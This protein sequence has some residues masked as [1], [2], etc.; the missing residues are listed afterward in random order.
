MAIDFTPQEKILM[1]QHLRDM[2]PQDIHLLREDFFLE[3][4]HRGRQGALER[5]LDNRFT[6]NLQRNAWALSGALEDPMMGI[7]RTGEFFDQHGVLGGIGQIAYSTAT[8]PFQAAG[9]LISGEGL[10]RRPIETVA[11]LIAFV[12]QTRLAT[13]GAG[14][15]LRAAAARGI[16]GGFARR[17]MMDMGGEAMQRAAMSNIARRASGVAETLDVAAGLQEWP[18]E[19]GA[20]VGMHVGTNLLVQAPQL[21]HELSQP[22][23]IQPSP[24]RT[25]QM[26]QEL[27]AEQS[28]PLPA[29]DPVMIDQQTAPP[30]GSVEAVRQWQ[31]QN[32][33]TPTSPFE[34]VQR[35]I[36]GIKQRFV[37]LAETTEPVQTAPSPTPERPT[38]QKRVVIAEVGHDVTRDPRR[39]GQITAEMLPEMMES[40]SANTFMSTEHNGV[41]HIWTL[42]ADSNKVSENWFDPPEGVSQADQYAQ[43]KATHLADLEHRLKTQQ[44][45]MGPALREQIR[46]QF[47]QD[48]EHVVGEVVTGL[49]PEQ[50]RAT[51]ES[52]LQEGRLRPSTFSDELGGVATYEGL[53]NVF[54]SQGPVHRGGQSYGFILDAERLVREGKAFVRGNVYEPDPEVT[55]MG[56]AAEGLGAALFSE[57]TRYQGKEALNVLLTKKDFQ[58]RT[59]EASFDGIEIINPGEV[60]LNTYLIGVIENGRVYVKPGTKNIVDMQGRQLEHQLAGQPEPVFSAVKDN[61]MSYTTVQEL[62]NRQ[63]QELVEIHNLPAPLVEQYFQETKWKDLHDLAEIQAA[64]KG[65]TR[66]QYLDEIASEAG[67]QRWSNSLERILKNTIDPTVKKRIRALFFNY[68]QGKVIN[69]VGKEITHPADAALLAQPYRDPLIEKSIIVYLRDN[70]VVAH[71]AWTLNRSTYTLGP[72]TQVIR[73]HM[74]QTGADSVVMMHNHPSGKALL[75][76]GDVTSARFWREQLGEAY[77]G[78]V[79]INSGRHARVWYDKNGNESV[80]EDLQIQGLGWDTAAERDPRTGIHPDDPLYQGATPE[81]V[82]QFQQASP[83]GT[84]LRDPSENIDQYIQFARWKS[85]QSGRPVEEILPTVDTYSDEFA[86]WSATQAVIGLGEIRKT[87]RNWTTLVFT[88]YSRPARVIAMVDYQDLHL[89]SS[90]EIARFIDS[91]VEK[92]GGATAHVMVGPGD[93]YANIDEVREKFSSLHAPVVDTPLVYEEP[94]TGTYKKGIE[95]VWVEDQPLYPIK[96]RGQAGDLL[97]HTPQTEVVRQQVHFAAQPG[98]D[99]TTGDYP[100]PT[101]PP[102]DSHTG[103]SSEPPIESAPIGS[104]IDLQL[105]RQEGIMKRLGAWLPRTRETLRFMGEEIRS[106]YRVLETLGEAGQSFLAVANSRRDYVRR[107]QARHNVMARPLLQARGRIINSLHKQNPSESREYYK[108]VLD[109]AIYRY[110][111]ENIG[112]DVTFSNKGLSSSRAVNRL[113]RDFKE[114][115]R[116]FNIEEVKEM[117]ELKQLAESMGE[118]VNIWDSQQQRI[119]WRPFM[120]GWGWNAEHQ[121]FVKNGRPYEVEDAINQS[122]TL[123]MPHHYSRAHWDNVYQQSQG[124]LDMLNQGPN[125][126]LPESLFTYNQSNNTWTNKRGQ[127]FDDRAEAIRVERNYQLSRNRVASNYRESLEAMAEG[128]LGRQGHVERARETDDD[129]YI[130]DIDMFMQINDQFWDRAGD[131]RFYGQFDPVFAGNPRLKSYLQDIRNVTKDR[132]EEALRL[133]VQPLILENALS[134]NKL[135]PNIETLNFQDAQSSLRNWEDIDVNQL[136]TESRDTQNNLEPI[137]DETLKVLQE[138]GLLTYDPQSGYR[139]AS[140]TAKGRILGEYLAT[141]NDREGAVYSIVTGLSKWDRTPQ[142]MSSTFWRRVGNLT[143][144]MTLGLRATV[145]NIFEIPLI[146]ALTGSRAFLEATLELSKDRDVINLGP[147]LGASMR[148]TIDYLKDGELQENY[149]NLSG[150]SA[151]DQ[152]SRSVGAVVAWRAAENAVRAYVDDPSPNNHARLRQLQIDPTVLQDYMDMGGTADLDPIFAEAKERTLKGMVQTAGVIPTGAAP[153]SNPFVD[154]IGNELGKSASYVSNTVFKE[155]DALSLPKFLRRQEPMIRVFLKY[156]SWQGQQHAFIMRSGRYAID[157]ARQGNWTPAWH[158]GQSLAI[159]GGGSTALFYVMG[160]ASGRHEDKGLATRYLEGLANSGA[161]GIFSILIDAAMMAEGNPYRGVQ[162]MNSILSNPTAGMLA[163]GVGRTITGDVGG[164]AWSVARH[165]PVVREIEQVTRGHFKEDEETQ[166]QQRSL[167]RLAFRRK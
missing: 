10:G 26:L 107:N 52:I 20:N 69:F 151:S 71:E 126:P 164:A 64:N 103:F 112:P 102:D 33:E 58:G 73:G 81:A 43:V 83:W 28:G 13:A 141:V 14:A 90:D 70:Q 4:K 109:E 51:Y 77:R 9:Q 84:R 131:I 1:D 134:A 142:E 49:T 31:E 125:D 130:R 162:I 121:N 161:L 127:T 17:T 166:G 78:S 137:D 111:E 82:Q 106:G 132:R 97:S 11:N 135:Y 79:V 108:S 36:R 143:T 23:E 19:I 91:E 149:L 65:M 80:D 42:D 59:V 25:V 155:Y 37:P 60:D 89:K 114:M 167:G 40:F 44:M 144:M 119:P 62:I 122:D 63:K 145:Q 92:W 105:R 110:V 18:L 32:R 12:P 88:T 56:E 15:G 30:V 94:A 129:G 146:T 147:V 29:P 53:Q 54:F 8:A 7:R 138:I 158:L 55:E 128:T 27:Q 87:P 68:E 50:R 22:Y 85:E 48:A 123:W 139:F 124:F 86:E 95:S 133:F 136:V 160:F 75:S 150:F 118:E 3:I 117:L 165:V 115:V 45:P 154:S 47:P 96:A 74:N 116:V 35:V 61:D 98:I 39:E 5:A 93:W 140:E 38:R 157:Q 99:L 113:A 66:K 163:E 21:A 67:E 100:G 72:P 76:Q 57:P 153:A 104:E 16:G 152:L 101:P 159:L 46:R 41:I 6:Q 24:Q 34:P 2:E 120:P 156:K 148:Q